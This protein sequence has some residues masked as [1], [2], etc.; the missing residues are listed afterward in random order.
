MGRVSFIKG[1]TISLQGQSKDICCAYNEIITVKEAFMKCVVILTLT[2]KS[3][4]TQ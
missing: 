2:I 3:C 4:M 1:R